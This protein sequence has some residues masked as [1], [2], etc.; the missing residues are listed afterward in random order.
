MAFDRGLR[1][2]L[3]IARTT[4]SL[5]RTWEHVHSFILPFVVIFFL[6]LDIGRGRK[7]DEA[8]ITGCE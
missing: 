8:E 5:V 7:K 2:Y 6:V 3:C 1:M 4:S